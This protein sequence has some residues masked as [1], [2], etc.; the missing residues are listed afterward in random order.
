MIVIILYV[1]DLV[2][3]GEHLVDINKIKSL[4]SDKLEMTDMKELHY[5]LSIEVIRTPIGI[6]IPSGEGST[7][8]S[9]RAIGFKVQCPNH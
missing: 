6:R 5:F 3:E 2:I 9:T 8:T 7:E 4:L 1:D